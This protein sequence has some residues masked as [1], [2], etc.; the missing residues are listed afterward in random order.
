MWIIYAR[1]KIQK[2][3]HLVGD[4]PVTSGLMNASVHQSAIRTVAAVQ[5]V[6]VANST[7]LKWDF[8]QKSTNF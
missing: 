5:N 3:L 7:H 6:C 2:K 1:E 8:E 4:E